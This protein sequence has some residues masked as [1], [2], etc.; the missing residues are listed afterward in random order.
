MERNEIVVELYFTQKMKQKE[1]AE[2]LNISKYI[3]S[4]TLVK[5]ARYKVEKEKRK[6]FLETIIVKPD[7][8]YR[9]EFKENKA[10]REEAEEIEAQKR[11]EL[12]KVIEKMR[13]NEER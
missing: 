5:D 13:N 12:L 1:I 2:K 7:P 10:R 3:V 6:E 4:R 8:N 9:K 11:M